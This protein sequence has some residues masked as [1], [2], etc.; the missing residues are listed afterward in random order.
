MSW[1]V[2]QWHQDSAGPFLV[3]HS[4]SFPLLCPPSWREGFLA[5]I[6]LW[7]PQ[8]KPLGQGLRGIQTPH[9]HPPDEATSLEAQSSLQTL[10]ALPAASVGTA[11]PGV[12]QGHGLGDSSQEGRLSVL[13][14]SPGPRSHGLL[15]PPA[16]QPP[17]PGQPT[18]QLSGA[19]REHDA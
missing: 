1:A 16:S 2:G 8:E 11:P 12:G 19:G 7:A 17:L 4:L 18:G 14:L 6:A 10:G 9:P 3:G 13:G 5:P 15:P